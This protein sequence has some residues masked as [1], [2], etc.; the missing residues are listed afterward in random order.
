[1][2][3]INTI[4]RV[5][6]L[7]VGMA[8]ATVCILV[9]AYLTE[10]VVSIWSSV[11]ACNVTCCVQQRATVSDGERNRGR[12]WGKGMGEGNGGRVKGR[13]RLV[14]TDGFDSGSLL[15]LTRRLLVCVLYMYVTL[16]VHACSMD[17]NILYHA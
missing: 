7:K 2:P 13:L 16:L 17:A 1:M 6:S 3:Y 10:S 11:I 9:F 12:V 8:K 4:S 15:I 5:V 14:I